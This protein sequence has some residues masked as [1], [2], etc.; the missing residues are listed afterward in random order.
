MIF[1]PLPFVVALLLLILLGRMLRAERPSRPFLALVGLCALQSVFIGLRWG[2]DI[3]ALRYVLPVVASCLPPLVLTSF[4]SLIHRGTGDANGFRWLHAAPPALVLALLPLAPR[5]I[6][7]ALI[8][9]FVG[10]ALAVL[11]LGRAGPD[12]LDEARFDG[13]VA[14]HRALVIAALSL[15][16]SA[17]FDF[18]VFMDFE[19]SRGKNA[20][21]LVSNANFLGLL[22]I[23]L[24]AIVAARARA[25][26]VAAVEA[27]ATY[28]T[29]Q[30]RQV[31]DRIHKLLVE[32]KLSR[33]ENLT[34]SRLARRAGV[35]ARQISGAVNRLA[36]KNVSRYINDFRIAEACRLLRDTDMSVTAVMLESGFQ[37][38][39]NFNREFRR[40]TAAS[41][42]GWREKAR[43]EPLAVITRV[44]AEGA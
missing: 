7:P 17:F 19:W 16:L 44:G 1:V 25:E 42:A 32:Q 13:A 24:T 22:L 27:A 20:A 39:S 23:G 21:F 11:D 3:T 26:P 37:T 14:A 10:Y 5:L 43:S 40:V 31:L 8:V 38:K 2:Y 30:D 9:I 35:P 34:L 15:C 33:D 4:R 6:D 41:P 28:A 12:A 18:A 36:G 29:A